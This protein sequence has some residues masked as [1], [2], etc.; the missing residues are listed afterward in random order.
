[1]Y[2]SSAKNAMV[3]CTNSNTRPFVE[4]STPVG[5]STSSPAG[6]GK[7]RFT[8]EALPSAPN[9]H[10][11]GAAPRPSHFGM[12]MLGRNTPA[13]GRPGTHLVLSTPRIHI[14]AENPCCRVDPSVRANRGGGRT[15]R[16]ARFQVLGGSHAARNRGAA[17]PE[18]RSEI[19]RPFGSRR[20]TP[21][22][23]RHFA[24]TQFRPHRANAA[25]E[26]GELPARST[27][28]LRALELEGRHK[29]ARRAA[30]RATLSAIDV[31]QSLHADRA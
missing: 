6:V 16:L 20:E 14:T 15:P 27:H 21:P 23:S 30:S 22:N 25:R 29:R 12:A 11:S 7:P 26:V 2:V 24:S 18:V 28:R 19:E 5:D 4:S 9:Q 17:K 13:A 1:V 31:A 8:D 10:E 3:I